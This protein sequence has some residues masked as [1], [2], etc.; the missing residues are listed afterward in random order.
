MFIF[1][2]EKV[3]V[4]EIFDKLNILFGEVLNNGMIM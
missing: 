1:F 3:I 2:G 4:I